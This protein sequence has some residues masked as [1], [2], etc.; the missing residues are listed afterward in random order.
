MDD[1][2]E[3]ILFHQDKAADDDLD[4]DL[5]STSEPFPKAASAKAA[6]AASKGINDYMMMILMTMA[7]LLSSLLLYDR[8][9]HHLSQ[10]P[11]ITLTLSLT[12]IKRCV[13][14]LVLKVSFKIF[15]CVCFHAA[16]SLF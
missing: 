5:A 3:G 2:D 6:A 11:I 10:N 13:T 8:E 16:A 7:S 4:E 1:G 12:P 15:A 9:L 14:L